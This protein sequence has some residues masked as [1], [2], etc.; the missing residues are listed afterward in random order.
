MSYNHEEYQK[1]LLEK[2]GLN[3]ET[4]TEDQKYIALEPLDAPEN[5]HCDGEISVSQAATR[6]DRRLKEAGFTPLQIFKIKR[7]IR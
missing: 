3:P 1:G 6:W 7:V 5:Y 4:L 2:M